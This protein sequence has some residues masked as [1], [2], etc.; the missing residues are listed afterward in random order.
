[1]TRW[2][3]AGVALWAWFALCA[4]W[5]P[6]VF[7]SWGHYFWHHEYAMTLGNIGDFIAT[8]YTHWNPRIG[9]LAALL[10]FTPGPWHV[11]L[12]PLMELAAFYVLCV[13]VAGRRPDLLMYAMTLALVLVCVP[14]VGTVLF[15]RPFVWNFVLALLLA[16]AF[17]V[18]YRVAGDD[19]RWWWIPGMVLLGL[20]AGLGAEHTGLALVGIA[21]V[22]MVQR[23]AARPWMLAGALACAAGW[24]VLF[25]APSQHVKYGGLAAKQSMVD[26]VASRG[27]AGN[28]RVVWLPLV[29]MWPVLVVGVI[30]VALG[31]RRL[32][33]PLVVALVAAAAILVTLLASPKQGP[34]L[35]L[36]PLATLC[37]VAAVSLRDQLV[38]ARAR[39]GAG[40]AAAVVLAACA[41]QSLRIYR[42]LGQEGSQRM[43]LLEH[44]APGT[45]VTVPHLSPGRTHWSL[46]DDLEEPLRRQSVAMGFHLAG[47]EL[48]AVAP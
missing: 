16:A 21:I 29:N 6:I 44:A 30:A 39:I 14:E 46:R 13:A 40:A 11:L 42:V 43:A 24:A 25:F 47:V 18:P 37:A 7:D 45:V 22:A 32:G 19:E 8:E 26:L 17:V 15:Y 5:E 23:R 12:T 35:W 10:S 48:G 3:V 41:W 2:L 31:R 34:R 1:M 38:A 4:H 28:L 9:E 27:L 36:A 20:V 33:R